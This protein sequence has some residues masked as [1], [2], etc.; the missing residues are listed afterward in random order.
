MT[1]YVDGNERMVMHHM[2]GYYWTYE[3]EQERE[4][5]D[6]E[7]NTRTE[8]SWVTVRSDRGGVSFMLH[9]G[10][11]GIKVNLTSFKRAEYGQMLKRWSGAFAES[12]GK[13]LMAQAAASLLRGTSDGP[14]LDPLRAATGRSRLPARGDQTASG[15]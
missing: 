7:G 3:Q 8:R 4:V 5:T 12:L 15:H 2:V 1:V 9:D 6:S 14:P 13:Q 10:T 11:G